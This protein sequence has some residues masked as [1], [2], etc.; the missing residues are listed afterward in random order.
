MQIDLNTV[1][2][3][4]FGSYLAFSMLPETAAHPAGLYLRTLHG[5]ARVREVAR[6]EVIKDGMPLPFEA[7]A[8]ASTLRLEAEGGRVEICFAGEGCIHL[9]GRGWVCA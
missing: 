8:S 2:F 9:R 5:E 4:R 3:S 1:P 6:L 7:Q